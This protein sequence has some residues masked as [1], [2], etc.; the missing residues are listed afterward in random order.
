MSNLLKNKKT[1]WIAA[2]VVVITA[3]LISSLSNVNASDSAEA[4][5][6]QV[7]SVTLTETVDSTGSLA[8]EPFAS[9][10]WKTSG[11][12]AEVNIQPGYFVKVFYR[13]L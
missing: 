13:P 10:S 3:L 7:V 6:A 5:T 1:W 2:G 8:A 9:L 12:V 11:T 4:E